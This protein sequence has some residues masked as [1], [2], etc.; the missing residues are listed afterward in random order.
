[1]STI[2]TPSPNVRDMANQ[3]KE[4]AVNIYADITRLVSVGEDLMKV[5]DQLNAGTITEDQ[6]AREVN[7][8]VDT[9]EDTAGDLRQ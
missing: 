8:L 3:R 6:A 4:K 2:T 1:M 9:L 7:D 5:Q